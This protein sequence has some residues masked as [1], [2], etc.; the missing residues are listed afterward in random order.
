MI[1]IESKQN[2]KNEKNKKRWLSPSSINAYLRCPRKFFYSQIEKRPSRLN[3]HLI[4]GIAV[5]GAI[6]Q[7]YKHRLYH[8]GKMPFS[9]FKKAVLNLF[10]DEWERKTR[11]LR[12]LNLTEEE[13]RFFYEDS[14]KM[15]INFIHDFIKAK[16][17]NKD[18][19]KMEKLLFSHAHKV[20]GKIDA[21]Y[22]GRDPPLIVDYKTCKSKELTEEYKRQLAIYALL[23]QETYQQLP[24]VAIH[25]LRFPDGLVV[26]RISPEIIRKTKDL[27]RNIHKKT[28]SKDIR[29]YPCVCGWCKTSFQ[30]KPGEGS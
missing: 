2:K 28:K 26:Y 17:F 22:T 1:P 14:K 19:P 13:I 8:S 7:F 6:H 23:Y 25:Y 21:F 4:R 15:M 18:P 30:I 3:I 10:K 24:L 11:A 29:D 16:G 12:A 27:I 20:L 9:E 5:H